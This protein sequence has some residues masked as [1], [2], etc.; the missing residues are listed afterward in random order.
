MFVINS[1]TTPL[2]WVLLLLL[3]GLPS[4]K[5][6]RRKVLGKLGWCLAFL[7]TLMLLVLSTPLFANAL[8]YSL[9]SRVPVPAADALGTLDVV[10]VLGGGG[11]PAGGFRE[12]AELSGV[13]YPRF[14][15]G[16]RLFREGHAGVLAFCGGEISGGKATEAGIMKRMAVRLGV[17]ESA[18]LTETTSANTMQNA[19]RLAELLPVQPGRR[20]GLV[21][22]AT[23]MLRAAR[24]F[25]KQFPDDTVVPIPVHYRY[26][27]YP[28]H[29][30]DLRPS[31][32]ALGDST[33]AIHEWIGLL[34]YAVRY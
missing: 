11:T 15:H 8:T 7:G 19:A 28:W 23:H 1:L 24:A 33:A 16:V 34:W 26:D 18:I 32:G 10:V 30:T 21:T 3:L 4:M 9:E 27:P 14:Y 12:E 29:I 25:A 17:P 5:L 2:V 6:T 22:S 13:A 20:M 31:V